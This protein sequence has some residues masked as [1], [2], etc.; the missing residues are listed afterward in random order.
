[1]DENKLY[2]LN[3]PVL[4]IFFCRD[5]QFAQVFEAVR[6]AKPKR[7]YLYQDGAREGKQGDL[8][9]IMRCREI[10]ENIDWDCEVHRWYQEKNVG[11]DPSEYLAQTWMFKTEK[12][13]IILEDDDVPS[14]SFFRYCQELLDYYEDDDRIQIICGM[15]HNGVTE[16]VSS[17][18]FFS[19]KGSIWGWATWKHVVDTWDETYSILDDEDALKRIRKSYGS[20]WEYNRFIHTCQNHRSSGR[21][22]YESINGA[23]QLL[24]GR[25]NIV[26]KYNMISNIGVGAITTHG[27]DDIRKYPKKIQKYFFAKTYDINFPLI[28]PENFMV[29]E[30]YD[31]SIT[32]G[33]L[34]RYFHKIESFIRRFLC[35]YLV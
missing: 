5:V 11:C 22:H 9:G 10:A 29:N 28:H 4:L 12:K 17:S 26:P 15:N 7:L 18:Y 21:A 23:S 31:K 1:M 16:N 14:Q 33:P 6:H 27:S 8:D 24:Y 35:E 32:I 2:E 34:E 19:R 25:V 13:G 30:Q 20:K 3:V